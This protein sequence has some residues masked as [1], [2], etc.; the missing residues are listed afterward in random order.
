MGRPHIEFNQSQVLPWQRGLPG[1]G[2]DDAECKI[3]SRESRA[4]S[5]AIC[6][7]LTATLSKTVS[8]PRDVLKIIAPSTAARMWMA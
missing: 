7:R 8:F 4:Q 2:R 3:L 1:G 5:S 6:A